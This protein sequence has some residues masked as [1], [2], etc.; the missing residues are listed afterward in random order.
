MTDK[1]IIINNVDVSRC[2]FLAKEDD[3]CS[4]SGEYR[5]YK[6]QCGCSDEEMCKDHPNCFYKKALNQLKCKE[7]E[8]EELKEKYKWYDHYKEQALYNKNLC[9]EKSKQLDQ[10]KAEN[11]ELKKQVCGLRPELKFIINKTCCKYN[12]EAKYYHE[13]IVEIINNL[14]KYERNLADIKEI[15][16]K[17]YDEFGNDVYGINPKQILQKISEYEVI[18]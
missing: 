12:I 1:Q 4:Y 7:Q 18:E 8:C 11:E 13:K 10:L 14:D 17:A 5:A 6:G 2:D 9:N 15:A 16:E 3:Y